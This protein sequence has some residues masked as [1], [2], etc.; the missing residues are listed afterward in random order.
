MHTGRLAGD[1]GI[2]S[3]ASRHANLLD[4]STSSSEKIVGVTVRDSIG[5]GGQDR[6]SGSSENSLHDE[7]D[8]KLN[9]LVGID[10]T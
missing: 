10:Y 7:L 9:N 5:T 2:D 3:G 4:L 6:N 8:F 1:G